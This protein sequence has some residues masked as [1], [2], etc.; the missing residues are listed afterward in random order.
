MQT[1]Q[2]IQTSYTDF[3]GLTEAEVGLSRKKH[4]S[5]ALEE[6]VGSGMLKVLMNVATEPMF[7]LLLV[8][9]AIYFL[10]GEYT[11]GL[12]MVVA[13]GFVS[14]ISIYQENRSQHALAS[15]KKL[16]HPNAKVI[17]D[18]IAIEIPSNQIVIGDLI[19]VEEG[20]LVP[21]DGRIVQSHDF[22]LNESILTGESFSVNKQID[23]SVYYGTL[24][25]SGSAV[26]ETTA[27]G[28]NTELG[29]IGKSLENVKESKTPLQLQIGSFVRIMA[30]FGVIALL[31]VWG[32]NYFKSGSLLDS[33]LNGLTLAMSVLPEE[34]PVAFATFMALGAWKTDPERRIG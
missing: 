18:G 19:V 25:T 27:I 32:I 9:A 29:K 28:S 20:N 26:A 6:E 15:L 14:A 31:I 23:E 13:I 8:A 10:L 21:A 12:V 34:I 11:D 7:L 5:N 24:V 30:A 33:L 1:E 17:R 22:A 3:K 2:E 16:T 4:G